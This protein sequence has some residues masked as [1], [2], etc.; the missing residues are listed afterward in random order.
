MEHFVEKVHDA[1]ILAKYSFP[2][3][4]AHPQLKD[5]PRF[6]V[7]LSLKFPGMIPTHFESLVKR[8]QVKGQNFQVIHQAILAEKG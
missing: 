5:S 4:T 6:R 7:V 8:L 2:Q 1:D 3:L